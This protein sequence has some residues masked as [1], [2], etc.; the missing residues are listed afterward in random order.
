MYFTTW[1]G[2][3][4]LFCYVTVS[5]CHPCMKLYI[6]IYIHLC[7][8]LHEWFFIVHVKNRWR[9]SWIVSVIWIDVTFFSARWKILL[10]FNCRNRLLLTGTPIQNSMA[11]V[12]CTWHTLF[13]PLFLCLSFWFD[14]FLCLV[15]TKKISVLQ[16]NMEA[17]TNK[18]S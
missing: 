4:N 3:R 7:I 6:Y 9:S 16:F 12:C 18:G 5:I 8:L 14:L 17:T 11:E 2:K 13:W 1:W 15:K 10:G